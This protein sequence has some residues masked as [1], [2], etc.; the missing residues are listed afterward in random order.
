MG[1]DIGT[2]IPAALVRTE[3]EYNPFA[4]GYVADPYALFREL[5]ES[6]VF[7][8]AKVQAWIVLSYQGIL[9]A[10][11]DHLKRFSAM[12]SIRTDA[13]Y[14]PEVRAILQN[15]YALVR[16]PVNSDGA[17]H[18]RLR[19]LVSQVVNNDWMAGLAQ[20]IGRLA[21]LRLGLLASRISDEGEADLALLFADL[22]LSVMCEAFGIDRGDTGVIKNYSSDWA[23][24]TS[25]PMLP[26]EHAKQLAMSLL[27]FQTYMA[28]LLDRRR[29][30]PG[31]DLLSRL[32][33]AEYQQ[34]RFTDDEVLAVGMQLLFA[35]AETVATF[36]SSLFLVLLQQQAATHWQAVVQTVQQHGEGR[37]GDVLLERMTDEALRF[38]GPVLGMFRW[39]LADVELAGVRIPANSPVQLMYASG[40]HDPLVFP[41]PQRFEPMRTNANRHL[42]FGWNEHFCL[43]APLGRLESR[44][45]L[46]VIAKGL[47]R[48]RL[49]RP[50]EPAVYRP[51][52]VMRGLDQ[53]WVTL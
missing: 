17:A 16:G 6:P 14:P 5:R 40:N 36:L 42:S 15:G 1:T 50:D 37:D 45:V 39:T 25:G 8:S 34:S 7:Y 3:S 52:A 51:N 28:T 33:T 23:L 21:E 27:E 41:D 35:G 20:T 12:N 29:H 10:L 46:E 38:N 47:P 49:S 32:L 22:P 43:G 2:D 11:G 44:I 53:L 4:P 18:R 19:G 26:L 9:Q 30:S 48:L 13:D 24:F 31:G